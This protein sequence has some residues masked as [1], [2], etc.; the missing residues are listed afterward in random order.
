M[1]NAHKALQA[2]ELLASGDFGLDAELYKGKNK[3]LKEAYKR[4]IEIYTIAHCEV[5]PCKHPDWEKRKYNILK[6]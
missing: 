6:K 1:R 5:S 4:I 3:E 2:I